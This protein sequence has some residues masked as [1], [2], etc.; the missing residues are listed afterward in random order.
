MYRRYV[1]H[2]GNRK[3]IRCG[4]VLGA[5]MRCGV[6]G[7]SNSAQG[8]ARAQAAEDACAVSELLRR[9]DEALSLAALRREWLLERAAK[10]K[11]ETGDLPPTDTKLTTTR[12]KLKDFAPEALEAF[13]WT[14]DPAWNARRSGPFDTPDEAARDACEHYARTHGGG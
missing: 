10:V 8:V 13:D 12:G 4:G 2:M 7:C 9:C 3:C 6:P 1:D 14:T 11:A 5:D